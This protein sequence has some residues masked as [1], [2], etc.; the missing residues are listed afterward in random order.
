MRGVSGRFRLS[1]GEAPGS[2]QVW[3]GSPVGPVQCPG[4]VGYRLLDAQA[5]KSGRIPAAS[6]EN[7]DAMGPIRHTAPAKALNGNP[8][9]S[10]SRKS[11]KASLTPPRRGSRVDTVALP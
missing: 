9:P 8:L 11:F 7:P 10:S 1:N 6:R 3:I 2:R 5:V 4:A